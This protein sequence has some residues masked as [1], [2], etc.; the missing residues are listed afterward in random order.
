ML[1][2][3]NAS[4]GAALWPVG[5]VYMSTDGTQPA[6]V[7]GGTWALIDVIPKDFSQTFEEQTGACDFF[8]PNTSKVTQYTLCVYFSS[9]VLK[10]RFN[11][12]V[13]SLSDTAATLGTINY[14]P[15]FSGE[16]NVVNIA[17]YGD[18]ANAIHMVNVDSSGVLNVTDVVGVSSTSSGTTMQCEFVTVV[19]KSRLAEERIAARLWRRMDDTEQARA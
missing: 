18:A 11:F 4:A 2:R 19:E 5:S 13:K 16:G 8:T 17:G 1:G 7:F 3:T 15:F 6:D 12:T 9:G 10:T 14:A